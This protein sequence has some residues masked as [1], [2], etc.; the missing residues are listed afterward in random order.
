MLQSFAHANIWLLITAFVS[1]NAINTLCIFTITPLLLFSPLLNCYFRCLFLCN[2]TQLFLFS[3]YLTNHLLISQ[4]V[5]L[6]ADCSKV[7]AI[8]CVS[9]T[10][11]ASVNLFSA[12]KIAYFSFFYLQQHVMFLP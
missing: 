8:A 11:I 10:S 4:T 9:T 12:S 1:L 7:C 3:V 5:Y 2:Y 6:G